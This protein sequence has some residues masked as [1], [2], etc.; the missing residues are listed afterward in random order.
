MTSTK[1]FPRHLCLEN[2]QG[3]A[4]KIDEDELLAII[5]PKI[6][7]GEPGMGKSA[8]IQEL[9]N[10]LGVKPVLAARFMLSGDPS[11]LITEGKPLLVDGLDEAISRHDG[12]AV[13][14]VFAKLEDAGNPEFILCCRSRE[15]QSR[16][17]DSLQDIYGVEPSI[18]T[19][20]PFSRNEANSFLRQRHPQMD[21]DHVLDHLEAQGIADLYKNPLTLGL[22]GQ[23]AESDSAL[24]ATRAA[25]FESVCAL[26]WPEHDR[27]RQDS[28]LEK[29][30]EEQALSAAG[31]IGAGLLLAGADAITLAGHRF[32][33][34]DDVRLAELEDLP[35]AESA[36]VIFSSK[37]F[38][39]V[40]V[41]RAKPIHRVVAE[42]LGARW[43]SQQAKSSRSQR[44]LLAQLHV[45][46]S[47]PASLR[48]LHAWLAFHSPAM[49][50]SVI[51]ADP[52][53]VLRYGEVTGLTAEQAQCMFN[54]LEALTEVDPYFRSQDW[55]SHSAV[56]LMTLHLRDKIEAII[57]STK[58]NAHLRSLL[59]EGLNG[60]PLAVVLADT[61]EAVTFSPAYSY[62]EREDA[63]DAL[64]PHRDRT[65]WR[66]A[67]STLL[68]ACT[69]DAF[70]LARHLVEILECDVSDD[71]VVVSMLAST[72]LLVSPLPRRVESRLRPYRYYRPIVGM[73]ASDRL[74]NVLSLFTE[75]AALM[76]D[77]ELEGA[78]DV[79]G[80]I[81]A[82]L[83]RTIDENIVTLGDASLLWKSLGAMRHLDSYD[84]SEKK[85]LQIRLDACDGLRNALQEYALYVL[86]ARGSGRMTEYELD[87]RMIGLTSRPKDVIRFLERLAQFDNTNIKA[88]QDWCDL[89]QIGLTKEGFTPDVLAASKLFQAEDIELEAYVHKLQNPEKPE[90]QVIRERAVAQRL[91]KKRASYESRRKQYL[92][93]RSELRAGEIREIL[94]AA[95]VYLGIGQENGVSQKDALIQWLGSELADDA[96]AGFE[97]VLHR[98]GLPSPT[99]VAAS[100][101]ESTT[102]KYCFALMAGL[103]VRQRA[104]VGFS[105]VPAEITKIGLLLCL[106]NQLAI[107][108]G[109][110]E[111]LREALEPFVVTTDGER[112]DFVR[113]WIE[114]SIAARVSH[115]SGLQLLTNDEHWRSTGVRLAMSWLMG[116]PD[117]P[118]NIELALIG[119]LTQAGQLNSLETVAEARSELALDSTDRILTWRAIDALV[120]FAAVEQ[121][122]SDVANRHPEFIWHLRRRFQDGRR[123]SMNLV[124][125]PQAKW[126]ISQFRSQ[127]PYATLYGNSQGD[128]NPYDATDFLRA[129]INRIASDTSLE[130]S[131]ALQELISEPR[132]GY[133]DLI[134]HMAVE[135]RQKRAE[136]DFT[137]MQPKDLH[138]LL[139][140]GPPSNMDDLKS[141]VLEE[142]ATAQQKLIGDDLDLVSL[143]WNDTGIPYDENLCRD[144]LANLITPALDRY[145][146]QRI[147]EADMPK[148]KRADLAFTRGQL[149]LP[150]E[151]K[152]QW[153]PEVW[154]AAKDQLEQQYLIDWRSQRCGIYCVLWFGPVPSATRRRL[155]APPNGLETPSSAEDM[156]LMLIELLPQSLRTLIDVVV[157]DF[158]AG[159]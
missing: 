115:I 32:A 62:Q 70:N 12:A 157:I 68:D 46:G 143:F 65:W 50:K 158:T 111:F 78:N 99:D 137:P 58:S 147:T 83:T 153:H 148:T 146:I 2:E 33:E 130:A 56:G 109:E 113:L 144:R 84:T 136:E 55:G 155:K 135:Q 116:Y 159:R 16:S 95:K 67:I 11:R 22:M 97:A 28:G 54:A 69:E 126:I 93:H 102:W 13:D 51:T 23:V 89:M 104:G 4:R 57:T 24:P 35:G 138:D 154:S 18:L 87:E 132:D 82:I 44:R 100:F 45:G 53:G 43:L 49:A 112:D 123:G 114:P 1:Y 20:E 71:V 151:V 30:S 119:C 140:D 61:L 8:L 125:I 149:Q 37:L 105:D 107:S 21:V 80:A 10:K 15:W 39:S 3:R 60:T 63:A 74:V 124:N 94:T 142:L 52:F 156:R 6:V 118:E 134:L 75:H 117:M 101:A 9:A 103:L 131:K 81:A 145:D 139:C 106:S 128:R 5:G 42:Y 66:T 26:I 152:G 34:D 29:I 41:D 90:Y 85:V 64:M 73:L 120:R 129:L 110:V 122:L 141:L 38:Q 86:N 48:G 31:A 92:E 14:M 19:I 77:N 96:M 121:D 127:W 47:V 40:G 91:E 76:M 36:R 27:K 150:M 17:N 7:L 79:A 59:I 98:S 72:G 133:S 25:L 88:R 108:A